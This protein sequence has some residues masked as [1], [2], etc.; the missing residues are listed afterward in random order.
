[1]VFT[2]FPQYILKKQIGERFYRKQIFTIFFLQLSLLTTSEEFWKGLV[3]EKQVN[4]SLEHLFG[5]V[6]FLSS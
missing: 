3:L 6:D 5:L 2:S 4:T 1:M